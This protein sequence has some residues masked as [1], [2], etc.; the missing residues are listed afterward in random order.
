MN[1]RILQR[2]HTKEIEGFD[3]EETLRR[4][5]PKVQSEVA[6]GEVDPVELPWDNG[7]TKELRFL[8]QKYGFRHNEEMQFFAGNCLLPLAL[9]TGWHN[10][11]GL[12]HVLS[13]ILCYKDFEGI[14][15]LSSAQLITRNA[16]LDLNVGDVFVFNADVGHAWLSNSMYLMAQMPVKPIKNRSALK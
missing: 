2:R 4:Y 10:D 3:P 1:A 11:K 15:E 7:V 13:W 5:L 14:C 6:A 9:S 12:G 16:V 8:A